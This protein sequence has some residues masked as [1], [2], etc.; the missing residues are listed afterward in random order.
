MGGPLP[1]LVVASGTVSQGPQV[2]I[3][4]PYDSQQQKGCDVLLNFSDIVNG[5]KGVLRR[6]RATPP[7]PPFFTG[8]IDNM[9]ASARAKGEPSAVTSA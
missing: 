1:G 4:A 7:E 3:Q 2:Q 5:S 9:R 8:N 6:R